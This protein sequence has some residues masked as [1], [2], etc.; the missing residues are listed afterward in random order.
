[1]ASGERRWKP[2]RCMGECR[3]NA[4]VKHYTATG[5]EKQHVT[6]CY[7]H[8]LAPLI[9]S[10]K[11][12]SS[13]EENRLGTL[14]RPSVKKG[15]GNG[16]KKTRR[17]ELQGLN[18]GQKK[19]LAERSEVLLTVAYESPNVQFL[20]PV[21]CPYHWHELHSIHARSWWFVFNQQSLGKCRG[22]EV[23]VCKADTRK[24]QSVGGLGR[25]V[26]L[27]ILFFKP[28]DS[29]TESRKVRSHCQCLPA[30]RLAIA[31]N[32]GTHSSWVAGYRHCSD[33]GFQKLFSL[34]VLK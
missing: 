29:A 10:T 12:I 6:L 18:K 28:C 21:T 24:R 2:V 22:G 34:K 33:R 1:M 5:V 26:Q 27:G 31:K 11:K 7:W 14:K 23:C 15:A 25:D 9:T 19:R 4:C 17:S 20:P 8:W 32:S 13:W 3:Y 16:W 30:T